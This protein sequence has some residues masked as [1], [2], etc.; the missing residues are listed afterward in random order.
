MSKEVYK[1]SVNGK[2]YETTED[3]RLIRFLRDD[4]HL[5]S[6][7]DGC[8]QGAC[9]TCTILVDGKATKAC[10][11]TTKKSVGKE[12]I[13]VEGIPQ[14][15]KDAF[16]YAF[17]EKG[18]VQCGFCIPGMVMSA[19]ALL[20][21]NLNPTEDEI[22]KAIRGNICRC[23]GYRKIIEGIALTADILRGDVTMEEQEKDVA[24]GDR[25]HRI[26]VHDKVLG[27]GV[28]PDDIYLDGMAYGS[29]V[30]T[31]YPRAK[32]LSIDT[33][34]AEA[35]PGVV[36]VLT[37][38]DVP[39]NKVGHIQQDWDVMIAEGDI[40]RYMGDAIALVV[41]E[42]ENTLA[43][44]KKLVKIE[45]EELEP[46]R[47]IEEAKAEGAPKVHSNGNLCQE[48]HV[49]R[50]N[51]EEALKNSKFVVTHH[52]STP[53]T[54]HAFLEPECAVAMPYKD[55]VKVLSTDQGA[56]DTRKEIAIM[57]GWPEEKVVVENQL[58]GGGFGGKED[59]SVQHISALAAWKFNRP[60]KCKLTRDES[61][62]FHPKR[63]AMEADFTVGV[64]ENGIIQGL[65]ATIYFD[66][67]AYASLCGPVLER[68]CTHAPGPYAYENTEIHGYGYY[69]NNPPAGAFRG[70]GVCQSN[71]AFESNLNLLAEK[72]GISPWEIR[73]RN[74]IEP[75]KVL[76]NG[77]IADVSTALKET[78]E[79]VKDVYEENK[80]RAGIACAMKNAGVGVGL[81][82]KGRC[83]VVFEEGILKLYSAASDI[84]Q[85]F[86]TVALQMLSQDTGLT[87]DQIKIMPPN[88]ETS[89]DSG[90]TSG[91]RQTLLT[92]EAIR[93][94]CVDVKK[95][96]DEVGGDPHKL[97]G[98]EFFA[99]YFEPTDPLGSDKPN[100]KSHIAYG[101]ATHLVVLDEDGLV[102]KVYAAHDSGKVV[103]PTSIQGQ[104][105]GGVLMG[106]GYALT[107]D[108]K[109]EDCKVKSKFGT[110]G[111]M[112]STDIPDINAI[113]VEKNKLLDAAYGAKGIG[114]IATIPTAP[115]AQGAYYKLDGQLRTK[116][117]MEETAYSRPKKKFR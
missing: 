16:V 26:D 17:G 52:Y 8:S 92:G 48:R 19:K 113:Y 72:V 32:V 81:P 94:V 2:T 61:L 97:E 98:K 58:I 99:E 100:P 14:N 109:L 62:A 55:G 57:F 85:G 50:G 59:V 10:I 20:D 29:A 114:E 9:G 74:A 30:R 18:A 78:L 28:Y 42:D 31:K 112:R 47:N 101:F 12:I 13:T 117:P 108:F 69:T 75:G 82:D 93:M 33:S 36:G 107:E 54:E 102:D 70:F 39:N 1:L 43:E 104:I 80:D 83:R 88:T 40:T 45:Y 49:L 51:A 60:V 34:E 67:G 110:L 90:T 11:P 25:V 73:Y 79:A 77:Q 6:V 91:S 7:K 37:A 89:P 76:P 24:I 3:K 84:G 96:L 86:M 103:N 95:A 64:D 27:I 46:V 5:H 22:K 41:A 15:E 68:A 4:L 105:E 66:T 38:K 65:K 116:F 63:H 35:L 53:F 115:A 71:F 44:A 87:T 21:Q 111:L 106:L 23:T 56:Y